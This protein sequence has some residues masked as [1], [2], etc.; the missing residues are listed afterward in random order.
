MACEGAAAV[1]EDVALGEEAV[2]GEDAV[3]AKGGGGLKK[4]ERDLNVRLKR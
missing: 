2:L 4:E 3:R 1:S